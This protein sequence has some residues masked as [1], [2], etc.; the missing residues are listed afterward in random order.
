[1][2]NS[3]RKRAQWVFAAVAGSIGIV[4]L[5]FVSQILNTHQAVN[6]GPNARGGIDASIIADRT[7]AAAPEMSWIN[8]AAGKIDELSAHVERLDQALKIERD[9]A[10]ADRDA[11][12]K[13]TDEILGLYEQKII[14][15]EARLQNGGHE[16]RNAAQTGPGVTRNALGEFVSTVNTGATQTSAPL[17]PFAANSI[18]QPNATGAQTASVTNAPFTRQFVLTPKAASMAG[19]DKED[20]NYLSNFLPAGSYAPA[21][22]LSGV[23]ASTGVT[24]QVEPVPV[25]F[26]ITGPAIT[27]GTRSTTGHNID[28]TGCTVT[29]SAR[30]DLSSERVLVRLLKLSCVHADGAVFERDVAGYMSGSGK[31]GVR[32]LVVS[33]EGKLVT[34]AGIAGALGGLAEGVSNV[35]SAATSADDLS[36]NEALKG[37]GA[38]SVSGGVSNAANTLSDYYIERAEQ[39]QPV[40]SLYGGTLVELV[41][42]EGVDLDG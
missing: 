11:T 14:A 25:V 35:G 15:L 8:N 6:A 41:F 42:M 36:F 3:S 13:H 24:S 38:T 39:Y 22:V 1:M 19:E 40:V 23:D 32:G 5:Y 21:I 26:R 27:A 29:G 31:A 7:R 33:R 30:G 20:P 9:N 16:S 10:A 18:N 4:A 12:A 17:G 34:A 2:S 37:A 28:L